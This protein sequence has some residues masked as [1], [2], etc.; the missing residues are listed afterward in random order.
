MPTTYQ[1]RGRSGAR[2]TQRTTQGFLEQSAIGPTVAHTVGT[3]KVS[4]F[5]ALMDMVSDFQA[6]MD[7]VSDFRA[8]M[9]MVSDFRALS[10]PESLCSLRGQVRGMNRTPDPVIG[11]VPMSTRVL[12][13]RVSVFGFGVSG[14][15]SLVSGFWFP[16]FVFRVSCFAFRV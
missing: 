1:H 12:G 15:G 16:V 9:D 2:A 10:A 5:R 13:F 4:D 7:M 11:E 8:L 14:V 6:L 3:D